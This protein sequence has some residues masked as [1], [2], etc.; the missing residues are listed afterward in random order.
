MATTLAQLKERCRSRA[1]MPDSNGFVSDAELLSF[2]N[3]SYAELYDILVSRFE[4]YFTI[5]TTLVASGGA[6]TLTLP[7]DFYKL[8]GL[9]ID[10]G[11]G[12]FLQLSKFNFERRNRGSL[13]VLTNVGYYSDVEY[14]IMANEVILSPTDSS[15]G[16]YK[17]W[18][19]PQVAFLANDTDVLVIQQAWDEYIVLDATRKMLLKEESSTTAIEREKEALIE[20]IESMSRD[21][22]IDQPETVSDVYDRGF[23]DPFS[24]N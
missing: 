23:T 8:R 1:D 20:R 10:Q 6:G 22:D 17:L 7:T 11:G 16:S 2:I 4:D 3:Q 14:R 5:T 24:L 12:S 19:V 15:D 13:H 21:R 18:Y 9:D